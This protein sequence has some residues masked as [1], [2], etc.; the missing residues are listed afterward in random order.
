MLNFYDRSGN[1]VKVLENTDIQIKSYEASGTIAANS[2][3]DLSVEFSEI[4]L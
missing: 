2:K 1:A 4:I 3:G